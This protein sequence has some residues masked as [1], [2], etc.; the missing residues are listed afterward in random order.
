MSIKIIP[1][2]K[3]AAATWD[4]FCGAAVNSTFLHTRKYIAYHGKRFKDLSVLIMDSE[5]LVGV[6]PAAASPTDSTLVVSHPGITYGGVV[7]QAWLSGSRM[8]TALT[9][10][11]DHY[12]YMGYKRLLYKVVPHIYSTVPA[13]DDLY[14]LFRL[15]ARRVRSLLSSTIDLTSR[16]SLSKRRR[17]CLKKAQKVVSLSDD[18]AFIGDLW[19]VVTKNLSSK[20]NARP[21]HS[22]DEIEFLMKQFPDEI[23]IQYALLDDQIEA[24]IVLFN[25]SNVCHTQYIAASNKAYK[26][27]ALDAVFDAAITNARKAGVR[28]FDFGTSNEKDGRFLNDGLYRLKS[29]FGGGG[30]VHEFY[31]M[32]LGK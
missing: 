2:T 20:H 30:V 28:Y 5:K 8:I 13:Q 4:E 1:Y 16:R 6:F 23:A 3:D 12:I 19:E 9:A 15:G 11:S 22:L 29:E 21:V 26:V 25:T 27:S 32:E 10:L 7:H 17:R 31:E 18:S 24:G 14:A